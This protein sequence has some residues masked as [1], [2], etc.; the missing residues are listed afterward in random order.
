MG[1]QGSSVY[2]QVD[3]ED[4]DQTARM[5][6]LISVFDGRTCNIVGNTLTRLVIEN[7]ECHNMHDKTGEEID[8]QTTTK[9]VK[10]F[11]PLTLFGLRPFYAS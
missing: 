5:C 4:S 11:L 1:S 10:R 9:Y 2:L 3:S 8:T 7:L 6:R